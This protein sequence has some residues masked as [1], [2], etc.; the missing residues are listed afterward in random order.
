VTLRITESICLLKRGN[1][2]IARIDVD[3]LYTNGILHLCQFL[4]RLELQGILKISQLKLAQSEK[5]FESISIDTFKNMGNKKLKSL[6]VALLQPGTI[7]QNEKE[8][9]SILS[10]F[11][12]DPIQGGHTGITRTLAKIKRHYYWRNMTRHIKE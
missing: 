11:Y 7:I 4:Q 6:R 8:I 12:D 3:G 1:K 2:V 9:Q 5:I 10:T